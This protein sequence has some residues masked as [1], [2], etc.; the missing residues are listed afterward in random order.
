MKGNE[1]LKEKKVYKKPEIK[2]W[3]SVKDLTK[4]GLTHPGGD[5]KIGS[6]PSMGQ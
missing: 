4:T 1:T 3:G 5:G 6:V 2:V